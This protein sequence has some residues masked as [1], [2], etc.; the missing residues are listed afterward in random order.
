MENIGFKKLIDDFNKLPRLEKLLP[1][2]LEISGQPHFENVCSNILAFY[3]NTNEIHGL[4][5]LVLK[6]FIESIDES[7]LF[8]Y[9]IETIRIERELYIN[10]KKRIDIVIECNDVVITIENKIYHILNNNL[11]LYEESIKKNFPNKKYVFVVLS[12]K[13]E[14]PENKNFIAVTYEKFFSKLKNNLGNYFVNS[15]NQY[16][17]FLIDF[18][19]TIENL[20]KMKMHNNIYLDFYLKN[21]NEVETLIKEHEDLKNSLVK[22]VNN[23]FNLTSNIENSKFVKKWIYTKTVIVVDFNFDGVKVAL[24]VIFT[25]DKIQFVLFPRDIKDFDFVKS[26]DLF[27]KYENCSVKGKKITLIEREILF[28]ELDPEAFDK[29]LNEIISMIKI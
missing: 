1:T 2:Y 14:N 17:T 26:L 22:K 10:E 25:F 27:K 11:K 29:D 18:I 24:D 9:D 20:T 5:D 16:S 23:I 13:E 4:K 6:S 7:L 21:K 28:T 12:L 8:E 19:Q 3:F 15:N